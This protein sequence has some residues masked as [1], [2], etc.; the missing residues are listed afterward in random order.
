MG[1]VGFGFIFFFFFFFFLNL[2]RAVVIAPIRRVVINSNPPRAQYFRLALVGP[3]RDYCLWVCSAPPRDWSDR[4][5]L[6]MS[7]T[8]SVRRMNNI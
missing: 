2:T 8:K 4:Y 1:Q 3:G 6:I 7:R 5:V